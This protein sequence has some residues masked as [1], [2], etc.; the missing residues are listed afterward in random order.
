MIDTC[1]RCLIA[2]LV[3]SSISSS[4]SSSFSLFCPISSTRSFVR[5]FARIFFLAAKEE[6]RITNKRSTDRRSNRIVQRNDHSIAQMSF[7]SLALLFHRTELV[8]RIARR[9]PAGVFSS[10]SAVIG[11]ILQIA[12]GQLKVEDREILFQTFDARRRLRNGDETVLDRPTQ[13]DLS[14]C[15][16]I[17]LAQLN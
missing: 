13:K 11:Q 5:S 12:V 2:Y 8:A 4:S 9:I 6:K 16:P 14:R 15:S 1:A 7:A 17:F 10:G 3:E